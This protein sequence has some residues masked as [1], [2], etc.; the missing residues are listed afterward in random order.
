MTLISP[1]LTPHFCDVTESDTSSIHYWRHN[2]K[3][4]PSREPTGV[5]YGQVRK[6]TKGREIDQNQIEERKFYLSSHNSANSA[7][8]GLNLNEIPLVLHEGQRGY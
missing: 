3:V 4:T 5:T 1:I 8:S 2:L 7:F 6:R